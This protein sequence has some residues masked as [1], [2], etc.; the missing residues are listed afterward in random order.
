MGRR[1]G[2][3]ADTGIGALIGQARTLRDRRRPVAKQGP[4]DW[5]T[6]RNADPAAGGN[7][8][9]VW[10]YDEI[11]SWWGVTAQEFVDQLQ[12]ITTPRILLRV[13]CPGGDVFDALAIYQALMSHPATVDVQVDG[14]AAS[15]ASYIIQAG[16]SVRVGPNAMV[17]IHDAWGY[18]IGDA[19]D[20]ASAAELL[21]KISANIANIYARRAGGTQDE[22]RGAMLAETWY[23]GDEAVEAGLADAVLDVG[24]RRQA[25]DGGTCD[26]E[27]STCAGDQQCPCDEAC[28]GCECCG[29]R[30]GASAR[31]ARSWD[32]S[33]FR[34]AGREAAPPPA[35]RACAEPATPAAAPTTPEPA[36][37]AVEPATDGQTSSDTDDDS[38]ATPA[39]EPPAGG[40]DGQAP[41][42]DAPPAD[43][44]GGT[45]TTDTWD[46]LVAGLVQPEDPFSAMTR[47]LLQ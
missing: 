6:V 4:K 37:P 35:T 9:E 16:D 30:H 32:L 11:S 23:T 3:L 45:S 43:P 24:P 40:D 20:M 15:A 36:P 2:R 8:T 10:L 26:P 1:G 46:D 17:M 27:C 7:S 18:A 22:W 44:P 47:G 39:P 33:V 28:S 25:A 14:L 13:N 12:A 31:L 42:P 41:E 34:Y 19:R 21:D 5:F 29:R 38:A